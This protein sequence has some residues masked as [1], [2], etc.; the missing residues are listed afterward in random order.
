MDKES[1]REISGPMISI[2]RLI[3]SLPDEDT[4]FDGICRILVEECGLTHALIGLPDEEG[5]VDVRA[6]HG[7]MRNR[8]R[9]VRISVD[10]GRPEGLGLFGRAYRTATPIIENQLLDL[11]EMQIWRPFLAEM[12]TGSVAVFPFYRAGNVYGCLAAHSKDQEF[13]DANIRE[14]LKG[15]AL[16]LSFGIDNDDRRIQQTL[17]DQASLTLKNYYR[18]LSEINRFLV[19]IPTPQALLQKVCD[20]LYA[21]GDPK[22]AVIGIVDPRTDSLVWIAYAGLPMEWVYSIRLKVPANMTEGSSV[23]GQVIGSGAPVVLNDFYNSS[24]GQALR[25]KFE[26]QGIRSAAVYPIRRGDS[27]IGVLI[28]FSLFT[29]FFGREMDQLL[30][31]M[32]QSLSFALDN[33][34]RLRDQQRNERKILTLKNYYQALSEI[35]ELVAHI[36][37]P[38]GL[39]EKTCPIL[40]RSEETSIVAIGIIDTATG[41]LTWRNHLGPDSD[42]LPALRIQIRGDSQ[43]SD[44]PRTISQRV[45]KHGKSQ[46]VNDYMRDLPD[47]DLKPIL[48]EHGIRSAAMFPLFR[49]KKVYGVLAVISRE[50]GFF[51]LELS[52]LLDGVSRSLSFA[53]A[54]RDREDA[55]TKQAEQSHFLSLHDPLTGLPNRRLFFDRLEHARRIAIRHKSTFAVAVL[56]LDGFKNVNDTMGHQTGDRLLVT[57]AGTLKSL[58]RDSDTVARLGGDEFALILPGMTRSLVDGTFSRILN[59]IR[60]IRNVDGHTVDISGCLGITVFPDDSSE[61]ESLLFHADQAMYDVKRGGKN[62]WKIHETPPL[63]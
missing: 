30:T 5:W 26:E 46:I 1:F 38:E 51:S 29:D 63:P 17:Q 7:K 48:R 22:G 33:L 59:M 27:P 43:D 40:H 21:R 31:E 58:L 50:T 10:Q 41:L 34:E 54:N 24:I 18:A 16:S 53:L 19:H 6:S 45:F 42:W 61:A 9:K 32:T 3:A 15:V 49:N 4:L 2:N 56:D 36:P 13:F 11:P 23:I 39:L 44:A 47:N 12:A 20:I 60:G 25:M 62:G 57:V 52:S 55:R 37:T 28:A 35:N 8:L 14:I